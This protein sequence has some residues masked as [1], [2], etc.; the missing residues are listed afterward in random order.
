MLLSGSPRRQLAGHVS[1]SCQPCLCKTISAGSR[2]TL[3]AAFGVIA[4]ACVLMIPAKA[5]D[6]RASRGCNEDDPDSAPDA[7]TMLLKHRALLVLA[8]ALFHLGNAGLRHQVA[9]TGRHREWLITQSSVFA[10]AAHRPGDT[11]CRKSPT[12]LPFPIDDPA[13]TLIRWRPEWPGL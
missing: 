10:V 13:S 4:I 9:V 2:S 6:D 1:P 3:A 8:L 11:T 12:N 7:F 5:I